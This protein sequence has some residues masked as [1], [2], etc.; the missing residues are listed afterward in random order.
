MP[1]DEQGKIIDPKGQIVQKGI[2]QYLLTK[3]QGKVRMSYQNQKKATF[4]PEFL[5]KVRNIL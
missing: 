3:Q 4:L 5:H 2:K 1:L